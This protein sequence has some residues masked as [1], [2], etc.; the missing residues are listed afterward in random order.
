[1]RKLVRFALAGFLAAWLGVVSAEGSRAQTSRSQAVGLPPPGKQAQASGQPQGQTMRAPAIP[2]GYRLLSLKEGQAIAEG[3]AWA[4][5]EEGLAPD[6][7]HLVHTLYQQAGYPYPYVNSVDLYRGTGS[8]LRV[9]ISQPGDLIVWLGHVGIVLNPQDHSFFSSVTAGTQI[10]NYSSAYWRARG[11]P[12]FYRY[13]TKSPSRGQGGTTE[14][15]GRLGPPS[16]VQAVPNGTENQGNLRAV[17]AASA[18][19]ASKVRSEG[20][21]DKSHAENSP[22]TSTALILVRAG[23][24]PPKA[25]DVTA[26]LEVA[27]L[28]AGEIL[29][30]GNLERLE[31]PVVVYRHLEVRGVELN[32]KR[33]TA[34]IRVETLAA[35][36]AERMEPQLGWE[37]HQLELQRTKKGW[38][39]VQGKEIAYVPRDRAMRVLAERLAALTESTERSTQNDREQADIVRF[40]SLLVE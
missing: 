4:D 6:C 27:N 29:R 26:A 34:A 14:A 38:M 1:M 3:I 32:G 13:L 12:R 21:P 24:Q 37:D 17:K 39:M 31:R 36:M 28:E 10:Q 7:S 33:G 8:F 20:A 16:K 40:M 23:G 22:P 19:T 35:L 9:R 15:A 30:A 2:A 5:D 11:Y 25:S 18:T